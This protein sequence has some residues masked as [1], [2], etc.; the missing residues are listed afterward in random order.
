MKRVLPIF[1]FFYFKHISKPLFYPNYYYLQLGICICFEHNRL[2]SYI[3]LIIYYK[4]FY[5]QFT[6]FWF[7]FLF[8]VVDFYEI[9]QIRILDQTKITISDFLLVDI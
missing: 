6:S 1:F 7:W 4:L 5:T 9:W 3:L 2:K 8:W